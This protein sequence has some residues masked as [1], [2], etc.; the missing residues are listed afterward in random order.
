MTDELLHDLDRALAGDPPPAPSPRAAYWTAMDS[1]LGLLYL[2]TGEDGRVRRIS[3][4]LSEQWFVDDLLRQGWLPL[5]AREPNERLERQL[6]EYFEGRRRR[7]ELDVDLT[8]LPSFHRLVLEETARIPYGA[9]DTYGGLA[10]RVGSPRAARAVGN[11]LGSNPV[12]FV[13]PCHRILAAGPKLGG[14]GGNSPEA[15]QIKRRLLTL[16][17]V[18][19]A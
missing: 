6:E 8:T 17:G 12:P 18:L 19:V 5:R 16:E 13:V 7:F 11:A 4:R 15:L 14:Y 2:A 10:H 9:F 3:F 1:P